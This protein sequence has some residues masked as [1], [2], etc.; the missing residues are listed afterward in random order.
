MLICLSWLCHVLHHGEH[1]PVCWVLGG[2]YN[3]TPAD[4]RCCVVIQLLPVRKGL[5]AAPCCL[6]AN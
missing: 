5:Q 2:G 6:A 3:S 4:G 1:V